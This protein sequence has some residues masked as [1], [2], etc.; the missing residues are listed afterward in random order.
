MSTPHSGDW[1]RVHPV[2]PLVRGWIALA[3]F[4][5]ILGR[6]WVEDFAGHD[7]SGAPARPPDG[8]T[9]LIA[10]AVLAGILLI[11]AGLFFLSW[12]FTRY[13]VT[14]DHVRVHSGVVFRQQ[15]QARLDRV[16]AI[17]IVQPLLARLFGLAE[18]RFEVAD[19]GE[20]AVR[21]AYLRLSD[22]RELRATIL[23]RASG[24]AGDT[25]APPEPGSGSAA[26]DASGESPAA[27]PRPAREAPEQQILALR[28]GRVIA[29]TLLS[30]TSVFL[31]VTAAVV[32]TLSLV[33]REPVGAAVLVPILFAAGSGYW[34]VL[35]N[36][37]NFRAAV[38]RDGIRLHY[39]L[40][41]T[42][43]Q[44]VPPGRIQAVALNQ[45][46]LWRLAGWYSVSVNVAGYGTGTGT[47]GQA[48][49]KLLPVGTLEE[50]FS[51]LAL[52][53]PS[54]GTG[55]PRGVFTAGMT[56]SGA[57]Y[58]FTTSP[59][60][61]RWLSPLTWR[62]NAFALTDTA[63][64]VRS[65]FLFRVL[66]VVP[67]GRTQ[68]LAL[69]QGP[70]NR[71]LRLADLVLHSTPGPVSPRIHQLDQRSAQLLLNEQ[72]SRARD[73]RHRD[74]PEQWLR[75][76]AAAGLPGA[77]PPPVEHPPSAAPPAT[78]Q[79]NVKEQQE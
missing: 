18:L 57:A 78:P 76:P 40:L 61:A 63:L 55:D 7:D 16:Q 71:S 12:W 49:T 44:T 45:S 10:A 11:L 14:D 30:G 69:E 72:A 75:R 34:S 62:R 2:S 60:R 13:Q 39:G 67:H 59:R 8:T 1:T 24:A 4:A 73:A 43:A 74:L 22:A 6:N 20:S 27:P 29:A 36:A 38:S 26:G 56:G 23:D 48:R 31:A 52:A 50:V 19:A 66:A 79:P 65:G 64:L 70:L 46:P 5:F 37:F 47:E 51:I 54:P 42:R 53:L 17:D 25:T 41:D 77:P 28:P 15:R 32:I 3:A 68:S 9:L 58:G 21:L 33:F 35:S